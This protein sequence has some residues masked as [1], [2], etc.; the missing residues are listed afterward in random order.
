M[1]PPGAEAHYAERLQRLPGLSVRCDPQPPGSDHP[2]R[3][4][5][6]FAPADIVYVCCQSAFKYHPGDDRDLAAI[7]AREARAQ[8]LFVGDPARDPNARRLRARLARSIPESRLVFVP[9]V[10][11][12]AFPALLRAGDAYLDSHRW[13]GGNTTLE[14][15]AVGL[16]IVTL[17]GALMRGR[18]T[19][20]IL[21]QAGAGAWIA[22]SERE[23]VD[24]AAALA[25]PGERARA[26]AAVAAGRARVF[27]DPA[28]VPALEAF[29]AR[30]ARGGAIAEA[31]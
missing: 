8:F 11:A 2:T 14:A 6:G 13:S 27:D 1:E 7:A 21:R 29:L 17:P 4:A 9:P 3:A 15:M 16:P 24:L 10:P 20:A 31:A 18:H 25:D 30:A 22:A 23:Y 26:R 12:D 28:P 5:L 19:A